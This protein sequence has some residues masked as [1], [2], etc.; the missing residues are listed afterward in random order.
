MT[1]VPLDV[2]ALRA[3]TPATA[4]LTHLNNAGAALPPRPVVAAVV[5]HLR[6]EE[7]I[8]GYEAE[9]AAADAVDRTYHAI[10]RLLTCG[11]DE[12]ALVENATAAWDMAFYA[13]PFEPGDR[14]LTGKA[15][16]A[17]NFMAYLQ[18]ARRRGVTVDVV[19]DD[20]HGQLDVDAL[21]GMLDDR[22]RL[23]SLTHVPTN[24]GLVNPAEAVGKVARDAGVLYLL[25]ACQSVGQL[26]VDVQAIGCDL[27]S[28]TGRKYV[29]GPRGTGALYV[30]RERLA[31]LD[32]PFVDL[33]AATWTAPD[34]FELLPDARRFEN[35]ESNVA[36]KIG[37]GVAVEY[38]LEVGVPA[39]W[40]RI[41]QLADGLR[42]RLAAVGGVTVTDK[43]EVKCGIVSFDVAG[44]EAADVQAALAAQR[45]NVSVSPRA[46]T[47]LD[48]RERDLPDLVRASVHYYNTDDELDRVA[49]AIAALRP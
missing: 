20:Q 18:M 19:P 7:E 14:I 13:I 17:S 40:R 39:A 25:D 32:P 27:L 6:R 8:G 4:S 23:I 36:A 30:R 21:A 9:A 45:I 12:V 48:T 1:A 37:L 49:A 34:D 28:F 35:W 41:R 24:G 22:V 31:D 3:D 26:P 29:R 15:E 2:A 10:A 16:Y 42:A 46:S 47:L 33:H 11:P 5:A 43:G 38:A 44:A